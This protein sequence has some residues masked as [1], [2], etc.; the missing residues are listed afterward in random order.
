[1]PE[2]NAA[3]ERTSVMEQWDPLGSVVSIL[4]KIYAW[5]SGQPTAD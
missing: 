2:V 4:D 1:M 3:P 5:L